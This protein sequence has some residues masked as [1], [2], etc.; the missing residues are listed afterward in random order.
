M[1]VAAASRPL[2]QVEDV[3]RRTRPRPGHGASAPALGR[4]YVRDE[5]GGEGPSTGTSHRALGAEPT[6]A[7]A[8]YSAGSK[9]R[10]PLRRGSSIRQAVDRRL[11][12]ASEASAHGPGLPLLI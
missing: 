6:P 8:T 1:A 7:R 3:S 12:S 10:Q 4:A 11:P 5:R 2:L 9:S